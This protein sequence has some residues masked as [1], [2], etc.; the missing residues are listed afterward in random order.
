MNSKASS[1]WPTFCNRGG[2]SPVAAY[3]ESA[4]QRAPPLAKGKKGRGKGGGG[5]AEVAEYKRQSE[6]ASSAL[7]RATSALWA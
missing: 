1:V 6:L 4:Y 2:T 7:E 3:D 5:G